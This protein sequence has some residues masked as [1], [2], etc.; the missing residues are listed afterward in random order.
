MFKQGVWI[1][2]PLD[3]LPWL[4]SIIPATTTTADD[5]GLAETHPF[6]VGAVPDGGNVSTTEEDR[7]DEAIGG[8]EAVA[9]VPSESS[10]SLAQVAISVRASANVQGLALATWRGAENRDGFVVDID[11]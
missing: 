5:A 3:L 2:A 6:T 10:G 4:N 7:A 1:A 11:K 9:N 8:G